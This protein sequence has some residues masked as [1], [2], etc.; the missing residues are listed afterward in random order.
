MK[1]KIV[2]GK[3]VGN[4]ENAQLSIIDKDFRFEGAISSKGK[5]IVKGFIKGTIEGDI[6]II[7]AG[8]KVETSL[9]EVENLTIGGIFK[10]ELK[11]AKELVVLATGSCS[12]KVV[13]KDLVVENGGVLNAQVT[14]KTSSNLLTGEHGKHDSSDNSDQKLK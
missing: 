5:L 8:G 4:K 7:S 14:C 9:T 2:R 3:K 1:S 13:C 10:G 11:V 6:V 12:G